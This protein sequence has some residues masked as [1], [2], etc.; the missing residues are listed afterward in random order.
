MGK[1]GKFDS[2]ASALKQRVNAHDKFGK[3]ELNN[4][5]FNNIKLIF[6]DLPY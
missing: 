4:W 3:N 1:I 5:I 2:D 6:V